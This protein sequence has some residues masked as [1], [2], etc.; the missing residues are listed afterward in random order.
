MGNSKENICAGGP[1]LIFACSGA[2][3]VGEISDSAARQLNSEGAGKMF[4]LAGIGGRVRAIM[5]TT[6]NAAH[7]LA[8]DGCSLDCV[9]LCIE[10]A[11][12][13]EF[14]HMRVTDLGLEKG[15]SPATDEN[16]VAVVKAAKEKLPS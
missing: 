9:K 1:A 15:K 10:E 12:F 14:D 13:M 11:G 16:I 6:Q 7:I 3:D 4:C 2:A 5:E 8:I